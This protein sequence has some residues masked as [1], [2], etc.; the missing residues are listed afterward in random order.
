MWTDVSEECI[1]SIFRLENQLRKKPA[2]IWWLGCLAQKMEV[3]LSSETSVHIQTTFH[4]QTTWRRVTEDG[5]IRNYH[6]E[7]LRYYIAL[8][9]FIVTD[10]H[11]FGVTEGLMMASVC[12]NVFQKLR[13]RIYVLCWEFMPLCSWWNT[14]PLNSSLVAVFSQHTGRRDWEGRYCSHILNIS[15]RWRW[16][17]YTPPPPKKTCIMFLKMK[18]EVFSLCEY[19]TRTPDG[20]TLHWD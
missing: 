15:T 9:I 8:T 13:K 11:V 4:I 14:V 16:V 2:C 7:N 12:W 17:A 20:C 18:E 6:C 1:T 3:V 19:F 5:N 10:T